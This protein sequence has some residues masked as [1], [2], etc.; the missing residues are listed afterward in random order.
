MRRFVSLAAVL[1]LLLGVVGPAAA[2]Q[3]GT[4]NGTVVATDAWK[5]EDG[6]LMLS[7]TIQGEGPWQ[8]TF[9]VGPG[10]REMY[11]MVGLL[12]EGEQVVIGWVR[13]DD[14]NWVR[15]IVRKG[16]E[17]RR[18]EGREGEGRDRDKRTEIQERERDKRAGVEERERD[19]RAELTE[20]ERDKRAEREKEGRVERRQG[21]ARGTV[22]GLDDH[23]G[24]DGKVV[25]TVTLAGEGDRRTTFRVGE[26]NREAFER[27]KRLKA[28]D[29]VTIGW[30]SEGEQKWIREFGRTEGEREGGERRDLER[31]ERR[32]GER[33]EPRERAVKAVV[34]EGRD[35]RAETV[36]RDWA[37][38]AVISVVRI[39][40]GDPRTLT[41]VRLDNGK[42]IVFKIGPD[43]GALYEAV[44]K[45]LPG[46]RIVVV[47]NQTDDGPM[48]HEV[49]QPE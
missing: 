40:P 18:T 6:Q 48:L 10:S 15:E 17:P 3:Q 46:K 20:R 7:V 22:A 23:R 34:E 39:K 8:A 5:A 37:K 29:R 4:A 35:D 19:K 38:A 44:G 47:W 16:G 49:G 1:T 2:A 36:Q 27:A 9:S 33:T 14:R 30:V 31:T 21:T 24:E 13:Q 28:G 12:K 25:L 41:V 26:G 11:A 32:E 43:R 42:P 45:L